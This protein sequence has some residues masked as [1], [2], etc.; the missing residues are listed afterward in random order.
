M[1]GIAVWLVWCE[2]GLTK[3][4]VAIVWFLL[5][6]AVN[7]LWSWLFFCLAIRLARAARHHAT[8]VSDRY[9]HGQLLVGS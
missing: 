2:G 7:A 9:H 1:M 6:L 8:V 5:Q 3:Q 4:R